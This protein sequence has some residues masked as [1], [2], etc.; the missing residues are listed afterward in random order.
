MLADEVQSI[1]YELNSQI[2]GQP[3]LKGSSTKLKNT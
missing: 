2:V 3:L 1:I